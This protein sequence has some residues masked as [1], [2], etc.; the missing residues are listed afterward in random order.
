MSTDPAVAPTIDARA[1][2]RLLS[3]L[4]P[5]YPVGAYT[6]SHGLE[7]AVETGEI[8]DA[9]SLTLWLEDVLLFGTGWC[10]AL[11]FHESWAAAN[12]R[13]RGR[14]VHVTSLARAY[15][16]GRERLLE[17]GA[18]GRAFMD[19]TGKSWPAATLDLLDGFRP[20][21]VVYPVAVAVTAAGHGIGCA[22]ALHGYLHAF[23]ANLV[24][25][26][27]RLVPLGQT[28]GQNVIAELEPV[29]HGVGDRALDSGLDALGGAAMLSD[30]AA[31]R[32]E[33]QYSRLFRS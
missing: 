26:A 19:A 25:A 12:V 22:L 9:H 6:Y 23:L 4:S 11:I 18:Q 21:D 15:Q 5:S 14:L 30:I 32:H 8:T 16:A 27:V 29:V 2:Y 1:L 13:D 33:T 10:D 20:G 3:W 17:S 24:S 28:D 7:W 31:M